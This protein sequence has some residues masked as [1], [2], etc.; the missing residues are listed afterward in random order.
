M[1]DLPRSKLFPVRVLGSLALLSLVSCLSIND[2]P[3]GLSVLTIVSGNNQNIPA[4]TAA[5][6]PLEVLALDQGVSPMQGVVVIWAIT[7][8][9]GTLSATSSTTGENGTAAVDY[10]APATTGT[11]SVTATAQDLVV[12]FTLIV[13]APPTG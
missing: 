3:Q 12:T 7:Q 4:G 13:V 10:T 9:G 6:T 8:G 2:I 1:R 11:V 5:A